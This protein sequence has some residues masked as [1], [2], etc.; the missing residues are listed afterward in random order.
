VIVARRVGVS[1]ARE[2][3]ILEARVEVSMANE[4]AR[5]LRRNMS[6]GER[7][8]WAALRVRQVDGLRFR[9]QHPIGNYIADFVCLEKRLIV[10]VD[11][12]HHAEE[13]QMAHDARR[14]RWLRDEG[15]RVLRIPSTDVFCNMGGVVD[16]IWAE[17]QALPSAPRHRHP[18]QERHRT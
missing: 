3:G 17:L 7:K 2:G 1:S 4:R 6:D 15:Y 5:A 8:S 10:E 9:R 11:G 14:D 13:A 16:A 12:G 18:H